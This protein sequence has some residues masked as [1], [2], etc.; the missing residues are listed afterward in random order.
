MKF[1]EIA[2]KIENQ[3]GADVMIIRKIWKDVPI[4]L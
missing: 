2:L 1:D 3:N 4:I